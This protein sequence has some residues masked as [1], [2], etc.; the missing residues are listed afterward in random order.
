[1]SPDANRSDPADQKKDK[2]AKEKG[3]KDKIKSKNNKGSRPSDKLK[4][5]RPKSSGS[6]KKSKTSKKPSKNMMYFMGSPKMNAFINTFIILLLAYSFFNVLNPSETNPEEISLSELANLIQAG[7]VTELEVD[8]NEVVALTQTEEI[9]YET[10]KESDAAITDSLINFGVSSEQLRSIDITEHAPSALASW[11]GYLLPILLP[12]LI[13]IAIF[14]YLSRQVKGGGGMQP[15]NFGQSKARMIDPKDPRKKVTFDD[16]AGVNEAKEELVEIVQFLKTPKKFLEIGAQIPKGVLLMGAPGTGKTLL[17]RAV[18]GEAGVPFFSI[19]GS[20][21]VEMFVGVGASRVRDLFK[22]AKKVAPAIVFIDEIDAVGRSRGIGTG[23]GNDEREQTLNQ[24]LV[25]MDGFEPNQTVIIMAATNRPDVLDPALLRPGRFDRR[26]TVDSPDRKGRE[27]IL[28]IQAKNKPLSEDVNFKTIA[29]RT[30]GFS[31][32]DIYSL[33]NEAAILAARHDKKTIDQSDFTAAIEKVLLGPER[34]SHLL[35][36]QEKR[37]TAYHEAGH[38]VVSAALEHTDPVHKVTIVSRGRALGYV[39]SLPLEDKKLRTR[40]QFRDIMA[41]SLGGY[42]TEKLVF[43]DLSTGPSNDLEKVTSNAR[44]MVARYGMSDDI[45]PIALET[46]TGS[47][48]YGMKNQS[49]YSEEVAK[50]IDFEVS[51]LINEAK[52]RAASAIKKHRDLLDEIAH[53]LIDQETI[54]REEFNKLITKHGLKPKK[55]TPAQP[56][57]VIAE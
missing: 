14:W 30:P 26:V 7:E 31:G 42:V 9:R 10:R 39:L 19:S 53:R 52:D 23:G 35:S 41:M 32:A 44:S 18:A 3:S 49:E 50:A 15:F 20:E 11:L 34:R 28:E 21:F 55:E 29:E 6:N 4:L 12:L 8:G 33:V 25:E 27:K 2:S 48:L 54:E 16:V 5:K 43:D 24:I 51:R 57:I 45:G 1:M 38:A 22:M 13:I 17:A 36:D 46:E 40:K 37:V 56:A 47:P